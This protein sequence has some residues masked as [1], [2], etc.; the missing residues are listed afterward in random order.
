MYVDSRPRPEEHSPPASNQSRSHAPIMTDIT[1]RARLL[2]AFDGHEQ[3]IAVQDPSSGL[4]CVIAI[5]ESV[6]GPALGGCRMWHYASEIEAVNDALRLSRGMTSKAALANLPFGGGKAVIMGD[7]VRNKTKSLFR[8]FGRLVERLGG[9]YI[10]GEDVGVSV[11]EMRWVSRETEYVI[12]SSARRDPSPM[13]ALGVFE[14]I[15]AASRFRFG[16]ET[17]AGARVAVQGLGNVGV[18]LCRRLDDAGAHLIVADIDRERVDRAAKELGAK[19]ATPDEIHAA[20]VDVF[21]PCALGAVLDDH[22]VPELRCSVIAG[23][24]NNQ[25]AE[26]RHGDALHRRGILYAPDYVINAGGL[27]GA[28]LERMGEDPHG[29]KAWAQVCGIGATLTEIFRQAAAEDVAPNI[30][31]DRLARKRIAQRQ[32]VT[33]A[34]VV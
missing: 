27:I 15:R 17:L 28:A 3:A 16:S 5:H 21:A 8:A 11:R 26:D 14:G 23:C 19:K 25:L 22:T 13:T 12:G 32:G 33:S 6:F 31:A 7:P 10:T 30:V 4:K 34:E 20:E 18:E 1:D 9:R 24:A 29:A 2:R